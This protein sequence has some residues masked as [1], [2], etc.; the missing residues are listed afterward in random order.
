MASGAQLRLA[1]D[2]KG[3]G[4]DSLRRLDFHRGLI[5]SQSEIGS[6]AYAEP[7]HRWSRFLFFSDSRDSV[8]VTTNERIKSLFSVVHRLGIRSAGR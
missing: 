4:P 2:W 6:A 7:N 8:S 3:K 5:T 1:H